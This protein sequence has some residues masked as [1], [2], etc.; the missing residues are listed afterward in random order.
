MDWPQKANKHIGF[1]EP[2]SFEQL[3]DVSESDRVLAD[4]A[5]KFYDPLRKV[6]FVGRGWRF[7][8]VWVRSELCR[9]EDDFKTGGW[10]GENSFREQLPFETMEMSKGEV[11]LDGPFALLD[12]EADPVGFQLSI[13]HPNFICLGGCLQV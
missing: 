1:V 12:P 2:D 9:C 5:D 6:V 13:K 4:L 8:P 7:C 10:S 11:N 3:C